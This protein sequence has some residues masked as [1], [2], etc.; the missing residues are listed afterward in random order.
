MTCGCFCCKSSLT[1]SP[2]LRYIFVGASLWRQP[3][4][5]CPPAGGVLRVGDAQ[6]REWVHPRRAVHG[7]PAAGS[8]TVVA[9]RFL[10][11]LDLGVA[12]CS[13]RQPGRCARPLGCT[14]LLRSGAPSRRCWMSRH[15]R[16]MVLTFLLVPRTAVLPGAPFPARA[17]GC[18]CK[19]LTLPRVLSA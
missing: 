19:Q 16:C 3:G 18:T 10:C 2:K 13:L 9:M 15:L 12:Q 4:G 5:L 1:I 8:P 7:A 14:H 17:S 6:T 11:G